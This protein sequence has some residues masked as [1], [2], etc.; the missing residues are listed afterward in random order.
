MQF[1]GGVWAQWGLSTQDGFSQQ[2]AEDRM[3]HLETFAGAIG[4]ERSKEL[5]L[6]REKEEEEGQ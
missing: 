4:E 5:G 6:D 2:F 3:G 1:L